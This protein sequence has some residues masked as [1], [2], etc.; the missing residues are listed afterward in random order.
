MHTHTHAHTQTHK[1][2]KNKNRRRRRRKKEEINKIQ[3]YRDIY[4]PVTIGCT[5]ICL[6]DVPFVLCISK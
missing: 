5:G 2:N 4:L 6:G 1:K 3:G